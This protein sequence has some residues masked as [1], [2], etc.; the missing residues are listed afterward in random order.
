MIGLLGS[1][2]NVV[3]DFGLLVLTAIVTSINLLVAAIGVFIAAVVALMP[4]LP[5]PPSLPSASWIGWLNWFVPVG[6]MLAGFA[7]FVSLWVA[8]MVIRI[9]LRW[10][11]A[12]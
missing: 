3:V 2:L 12:L 11:K 8:L 10:A 9:P 7:T 5:S 4:S 1:L 6:P